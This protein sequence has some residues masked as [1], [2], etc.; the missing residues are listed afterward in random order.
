MADSYVDFV[1]GDDGNDGLSWANAKVT[2]PAGVAVGGAGDRCFVKADAAQASIDYIAG[3]RTVTLPGTV[4]NPSFII[5]VKPG[6]TNEPPTASDLLDRNDQGTNKLPKF[7]SNNMSVNFSGSF[8]IIYGMLFE[9]GAT[10]N[11]NANTRSIKW[12]GSEIKTGQFNASGAQNHNELFDCNVIFNGT[13]N[14]ITLTGGATLE[15][16]GG[17]F[18][19]A[20]IVH[21]INAPSQG[22]AKFIGVDLSNI[23]GNF[24]PFSG[25]PGI[26]FD[27]LV[28][29]CKVPS[30]F[31]MANGQG[32]NWGYDLRAIGC[33]NATGKG[34][35]QS[36]LDFRRATY[37]GLAVA[38]TTVVRTG[39][40]T[41]GASGSHSWKL[42]PNVNS[43]LEGGTALVSP[44]MQVW[45][46]GTG[47]T[48]FTFTVH[49][50]NSGDADYNTDDVWLELFVPDAAAGAANHNQ[51]FDGMPGNIINGSVTAITDDT[52]STWGAGGNN[53]QKL[54][55]AATP[56][57][58][59]L[60]YARVH[61][62]KRFAA[63]PESL[64][65][66]PRLHVSSDSGT[67]K[68]FVGPVN[69]AAFTYPVGGGAP[70]HANMLGGML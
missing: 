47:S 69:G 36:F 68:T 30:G 39:G 27:I 35:G 17:K 9:S 4:G 40:A 19:G 22:I 42:T 18:S 32:G 64:Y 45:V 24:V 65:V 2:L 46:P 33:S 8:V 14:R 53:H 10:G 12:F 54:S 41:D 6:T 59:G 44:W 61:F 50:A 70:G 23:A 31:T 37:Q 26:N 3:N 66:D 21:V 16:Y 51:F 15:M 49:I 29:N 55:V 25:T 58:E 38:E 20:A 5:G 57:F 34:S 60:V 43:T 67:F 56:D 52:G 1:N 63:S 28:A 7:G 62:A 13:G 48:A 11:I